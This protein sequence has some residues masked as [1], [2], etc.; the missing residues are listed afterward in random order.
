M[1][2]EPDTTIV[3]GAG[4]TGLT[5]ARRLMQAGRAVL[6]LDKGRGIGGRVATRRAAGLHFDH[7]AQYVSAQGA[8]FAAVLGALSAS[9]HVAPWQDRH[10]G[11]PGMSALAK[12]IGA[13]LTIRQEALVTGLSRHGTGWRVHLGDEAL[14][15]SHVICTTPTP[16]VAGIIGADHPLIARLADVTYAPNLTLMAGIDGPAPFVT[17]RDAKAD[18]AWIAQ[19]STKPHRPQGPVA[20]VAQASTAFSE[21][22]LELDK[23]AIADLMLPLLLDRLGAAPAQVRYA[24]AHRWRYAQVT[25]A[26]GAPFLRDDTG[27]LYL[28]GDWCL[29]PKV[30]DAWTS[31]TAIADDLLARDAG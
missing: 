11:T 17:A 30:E 3:I 29:G 20:W 2:A 8:G 7:G 6:V 19:D 10:V 18:L 21:T 16:Q 14:S 9:G 15:A 12:G 26:L 13:G 27:T 24:A 22:H 4:I 23:E 25:Q 31:G 28:G 5:A 1:T